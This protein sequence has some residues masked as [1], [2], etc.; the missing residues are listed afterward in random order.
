MSKIL[1][2]YFAQG[3]H[4]IRVVSEDKI[5]LANSKWTENKLT[6]AEAKYWVNHHRG[7]LGVVC[8]DQSNGL[9]VFDFDKRPP[10][11]PDVLAKLRTLNTLVCFTPK[12]LH[13]Y[14]RTKNYTLA[15][16]K[17]HLYIGD[18]ELLPD[19]VRWTNGY[20][21]VPPSRVRKGNS[22]KSYWFLDDGYRSEIREI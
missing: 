16:E 7:N 12:G 9:V 18:T 11:T 6:L 13:I 22:L 20:V 14:F 15:K 2:Y 19:K 10:L 5:P 8:G 1:E 17:F 4:L 21:L 3:F